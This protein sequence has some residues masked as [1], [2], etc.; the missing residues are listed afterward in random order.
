MS[1]LRPRLYC[2]FRWTALS[3]ILLAAGT[4]LRAQTRDFAILYHERVQE[5]SFVEGRAR[6]QALGDGPSSTPSLSFVA[7]GR[8]FDVDL[9][10]NDGLTSSLDAS[11]RSRL[12]GVDVYQ[13]EL[14]NTPRSWVRLTHYR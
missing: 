2:A 3:L 5:L 11:A 10:H 8:R 14:R 6:P 12:A 13:G 1:Q 7:F 4:P 9:R